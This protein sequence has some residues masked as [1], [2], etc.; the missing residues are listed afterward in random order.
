MMNFPRFV[1]EKWSTSLF[2]LSPQAD[3]HFNNGVRI[4]DAFP[5]RDDNVH[6]A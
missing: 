3:F 5:D 4:A 1:V 2:E 6:A